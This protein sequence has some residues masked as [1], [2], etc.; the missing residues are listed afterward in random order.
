MTMIHV[1]KTFQVVMVVMLLNGC[2]SPKGNSHTPLME[3]LDSVLVDISRDDRATIH[4][5]F[6]SLQEQ[7]NRQLPPD[8]HISILVKLPRT[9]PPP[10]P[11]NEIPSIGGH[12]RRV[13]VLEAIRYLTEVNH[14]EYTV[15]DAARQIIVT[16]R[17]R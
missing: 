13:S 5:L 11:E 10:Q 6:E 4:T 14:M 16:K 3:E 15:R 12:I 9:E 2:A 8:R 1:I 17:K 7:I